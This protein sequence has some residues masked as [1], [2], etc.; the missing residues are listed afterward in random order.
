MASRGGGDGRQDDGGGGGNGGSSALSGSAEQTE[1][2]FRLHLYKAKILLLQEQVSREKDRETAGSRRLLLVLRAMYQMFSAI[3]H[4]VK[5][6]QVA[7]AARSY[8]KLAAPNVL[9]QH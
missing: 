3:G 2:A 5:S 1:F 6:G 8:K 9:P 7:C 4:Q